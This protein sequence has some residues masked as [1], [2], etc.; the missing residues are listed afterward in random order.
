MYPASIASEPRHFIGVTLHPN[1]W[2][3]FLNALAGYPYLS[4]VAFVFVN[5][6]TV[7]PEETRNLLRAG[8]ETCLAPLVDA[9]L[10]DV[11]FEE[12][13]ACSAGFLCRILEGSENLD[14]DHLLRLL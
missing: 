7:V 3:D 2:R 4:R 12:R 9:R 5:N 8:L 1:F 11:R 10:L 13:A 6:L 14:I